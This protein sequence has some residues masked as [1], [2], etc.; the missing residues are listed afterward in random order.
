V[1]GVDFLPEYEKRRRRLVK[2]VRGGHLWSWNT[3]YMCFVGGAWPLLAVNASAS[4]HAAASRRS[5][6]LGKQLC[7]IIPR[8]RGGGHSAIPQSVRLPAAGRPPEM[9]G[10]PTGPRTDVDPPRIELLQGRI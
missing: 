4:S 10:L 1:H 8:R 3:S 9:C 5:S 2:L 6:R 7:F